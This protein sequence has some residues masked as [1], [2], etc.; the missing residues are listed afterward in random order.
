MDEEYSSVVLCCIKC[1]TQFPDPADVTEY[2]KCIAK[3]VE[4]ASKQKTP[5]PSQETGASPD[6]KATPK[7]AP[8]DKKSE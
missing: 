6:P 4:E 2:A 7:K 5:E 3:C 8:R 1:K